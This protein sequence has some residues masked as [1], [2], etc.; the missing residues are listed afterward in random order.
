MSDLKARGADTVAC[1]SVNDAFVMDAWG[2]SQ[3]AD[4]ILML[5]DGN[6]EFAAATGMVLDASGG[7]LG[8]RCKRWAMIVKDGV[9]EHC[10]VDA[11]GIDLTLAPVLAAKL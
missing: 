10:V 5:A 2:K 6:G 1:L 4:G 9:V 3:N 8:L 11:K 7:G